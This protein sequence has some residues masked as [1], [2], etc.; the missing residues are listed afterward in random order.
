MIRDVNMR[1][2]EKWDETYIKSNI[3]VVVLHLPAGFKEA[4][5]TS[6]TL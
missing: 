5:I 4:V 2:H 1:I 6:P 3:I